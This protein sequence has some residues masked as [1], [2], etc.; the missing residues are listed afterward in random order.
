MVGFQTRTLLR[1]E[2]AQR[3]GSS[4]PT[5]KPGGRSPVVARK[6]FFVD[7]DSNSLPLRTP[8]NG[9]WQPVAVANCVFPL[10]QRVLRRKRHLQG[11]P[12]ITV[13]PDQRQCLVEARDQRAQGA[14]V[15]W[16]RKAGKDGGSRVRPRSR[17]ARNR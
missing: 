13:D 12:F 17:P 11:R 16:A 6:T 4:T 3:S 10:V 14:S 5:L 8:P 7:E 9:P 1:Y 2:T 15:V